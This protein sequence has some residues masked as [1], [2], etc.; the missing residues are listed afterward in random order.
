MKNT[1]YLTELFKK[2]DILYKWFEYEK[3]L[4]QYEHRLLELKPWDKEYKETAQKFLDMRAEYV[5]WQ[6]E[7]YGL[8][9]A[10]VVESV[11]E[12]PVEPLELLEDTEE[13]NKEEK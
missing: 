11:E 7:E 5:K 8:I 3:S 10:E 1:D 4:E 2:D 6:E 12:S 13:S 9:E